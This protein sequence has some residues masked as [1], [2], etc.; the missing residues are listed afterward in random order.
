MENRAVFDSGFRDTSALASH[1]AYTSC[2]RVESI[3]TMLEVLWLRMQLKNKSYLFALLELLNEIELE[4]LIFCTFSFFFKQRF[5][6]MHMVIGALFHGLALEC[7]YVLFAL[8]PG[9]FSR[10]DAVECKCN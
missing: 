4:G 1:F 6:I 3:S 9:H 8:E 5:A 2:K 10:I 7:N